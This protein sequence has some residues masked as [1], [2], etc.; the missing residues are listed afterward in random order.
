MPESKYV[1]T[2]SLK[3]MVNVIEDLRTA[4]RELQN[5]VEDQ[6][7]SLELLR[8]EL[9]RQ[10]LVD[11]RMSK[12]IRKCRQDLENIKANDIKAGDAKATID[13]KA[14]GDVK[15]TDDVKSG[16]EKAETADAGKKSAGKTMD[17]NAPIMKGSGFSHIT[18]GYL[19]SLGKK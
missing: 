14:A 5:R 6:D 19:R 1:S 15:A 17:F 9:E 18:T 16:S 13:A 7:R 8:A 12:E 4:I 10:I 11:D 3:T 2:S